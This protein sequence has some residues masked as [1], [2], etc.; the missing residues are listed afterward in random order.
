MLFWG[1][2][3]G[4]YSFAFIWLV[5]PIRRLCQLHIAE[6]GIYTQAISDAIVAPLYRSIGQMFGSV[7]MNLIHQ[8]THAGKEY[9]V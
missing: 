6:M 9:Q 3:L 7:R 1:L 4:A 2:F 5:A 8:Q